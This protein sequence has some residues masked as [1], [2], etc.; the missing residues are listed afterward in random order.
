MSE[1]V[2][3]DSETDSRVTASVSAQTV[4]TLCN[5]SYVP[6]ARM[7]ATLPFS[8]GAPGAQ[9]VVSRA[10]VEDISREVCAEQMVDVCEQP[11]RDRETE[12]SNDVQIKQKEEAGK[13]VAEDVIVVQGEQ[14]REG[15]DKQVYVG[16][17]GDIEKDSVMA[18]RVEM[19][20]ES[21][22]TD[23]FAAES[24]DQ[25]QTLKPMQEEQEKKD[26]AIEVEITKSKATAEMKMPLS[27]GHEEVKCLGESAVKTNAA[28]V[29]EIKAVNSP[30]VE[31]NATSKASTGLAALAEKITEKTGKLGKRKSID[32]AAADGKI[33]L[34]LW[35][36][37]LT[38]AVPNQAILETHTD[39]LLSQRELSGET[40]NKTSAATTE[41]VI[42]ELESVIQQ[43]EVAANIDRPVDK[44]VETAEGEIS[45]V[46]TKQ[47]VDGTVVCDVAK[48]AGA[49][50][51]IAVES[52]SGT[53]AVDEA[54]PVSAEMEQVEADSAS[55]PTAAGIEERHIRPAHRANSEPHLV[56]YTLT[57]LF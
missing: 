13:D 46:V 56:R 22:Q 6:D 54:R 29:S 31:V 35:T 40:T 39:T 2:Q 19:V 36:A 57:R 37:G 5:C 12:G 25:Q 11:S 42:Q 34:P 43:A 7:L 14:A 55:E 53:S 30:Q 45:P 21:Q 26:P 24:K 15:T 20:D 17:Q 27:D 51:S 28:A 33:S 23:L 18:G 1:G 44:T 3:V 50:A 16:E 47:P 10:T 38:A 52:D 8:H 48:P 32:T 41:S 4:M 49:A 9:V